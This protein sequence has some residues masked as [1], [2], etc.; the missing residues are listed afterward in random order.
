[1]DDFASSFEGADVLVCTDIYPAGEQP[2]E[3]VTTEALLKK[4]NKS[5]ADVRHVRDVK[6]ASQSALA[7]VRPGDVVLTLG[8]GNIYTQ[9]RNFCMNLQERADKSMIAVFEDLGDRPS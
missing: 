4:M 8:A 6:A 9:A 2:I 7:I 3:G 5:A 1:M